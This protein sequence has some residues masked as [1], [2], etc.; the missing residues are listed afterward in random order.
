MHTTYTVCWWLYV[1]VYVYTVFYYWK[2]TI[3]SIPIGSDKKLVLMQ[4]CVCYCSISFIVSSHAFHSLYRCRYRGKESIWA[5]CSHVRLLQW[6]QRSASAL[7][8][9]G[10]L[11]S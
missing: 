6:P 2:H 11:L 9:H 8:E 10:E 4:L 5:D 3:H 1:V 7:L